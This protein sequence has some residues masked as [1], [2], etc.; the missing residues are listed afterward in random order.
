VLDI[1]VGYDISTASAQEVIRGVL[2]R[3]EA[4]MGDPEPLVLVDT[5]GASTVNLKVYYWI[6]GHRYSVVKVKSALLRLMKKALTD[7]GISMPDEAREV[8]FPQGVPVLHLEGQAERAAQRMAEHDIEETVRAERDA[9][10][11]E[12]DA[13]SSE[14]DLSNERHDIE[15]QAASAGTIEGETDLLDEKESAVYRR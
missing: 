11:S 12:E 4:V 6:D 9:V 13:T 5:L 2:G 7:A 10:E 14:G 15:S 8:I 3:H 1:G